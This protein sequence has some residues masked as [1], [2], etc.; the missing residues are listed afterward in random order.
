MKNLKGKTIIKYGNDG[1]DLVKELQGKFLF[2]RH[3]KEAIELDSKNLLKMLFDMRGYIKE[4]YRE[5]FEVE[6]DR[7]KDKRKQIYGDFEE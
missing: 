6:Y 2:A 5:A 4:E 7:Y 1:K 3:V